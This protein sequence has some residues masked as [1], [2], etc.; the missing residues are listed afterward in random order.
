V[1]QAGAKLTQRN[2]KGQVPS[3]GRL[4]WLQQRDI[5][6]PAKIGVE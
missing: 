4:D 3:E 5:I 2:G 1:L 6:E